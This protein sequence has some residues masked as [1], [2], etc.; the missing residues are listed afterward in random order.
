[1]DTANFY[2][3]FLKCVWFM[4]SAR[5]PL[6]LVFSFLIFGLPQAVRGASQYWDNPAP[7]G[8]WHT[9]FWSA[10]PAGG[11]PLLVWTDGNS[12]VFSATNAGA[13]GDFTVTLDSNVTDQNLTYTGGNSGSTFQ[14]AVGVGDTI[15]MQSAQ[16]NVAIDAGTTMVIAPNIAGT[17]NLTQNGP[18]TLTLTGTNSYSGGTSVTGGALSVSTDAA[19]GNVSGGITLSGGTLVISSNGF[20][21]G[22]TLTLGPGTNTLTAP[23]N[24]TFRFV[25]FTGVLTGS[26]ALT[27]GDPTNSLEFGVQLTNPGND[28]TGGTTIMGGAA[29]DVS[30]D[31][32]LGNTLGGITLMGG[33]LLTDANGFSSTRPITLVPSGPSRTF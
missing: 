31:A 1:M 12:A 28:Y 6:V 3:R 30:M 21:S 18:G 15:T 16:M 2:K 32:Q 20:V 4:N 5:S 22:R 26:G 8:V 17:G 13:T 19:L 27:V 25:T 24:N 23:D 9:P 11:A 29:L 7:S 10:F 14:I 33:T